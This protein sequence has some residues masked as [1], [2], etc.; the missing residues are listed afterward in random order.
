MP[1]ITISMDKDLLEKAKLYAAARD[2]SLSALLREDLSAKID[3]ENSDL[4]KKL[5]HAY[6]ITG[7]SHGW[8]WN[9][10]ELYVPR[11]AKLCN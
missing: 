11:E 6:A 4:L 2:K 1:N 7:D 9:R 5:H 8:K 10:K 3:D